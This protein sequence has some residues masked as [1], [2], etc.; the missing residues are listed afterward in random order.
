MNRT[1]R[2]RTRSRDKERSQGGRVKSIAGGCQTK[3]NQSPFDR[4]CRNLG[5]AKL[6]PLL[7]SCG[8]VEFEIAS[9]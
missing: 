9:S 3:A 2:T 4:G 1:D 5:Y 7:K 8:A 6:P